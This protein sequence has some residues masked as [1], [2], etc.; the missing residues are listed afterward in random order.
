MLQVHNKPRSLNTS[1][2]CHLKYALCLTLQLLPQYSWNIHAGYMQYVPHGWMWH[3]AATI[4][5]AWA[6]GGQSRSRTWAVM[7]F[8]FTFAQGR[9]WARKEV[10]KDSLP[11]TCVCTQ[12]HTN[13]GAQR[14]S[15][16]VNS[17]KSSVPSKIFFIFFPLTKREMWLSNH[18]AILVINGEFRFLSSWSNWM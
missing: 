14:G 6:E 17:V 18:G 13:T 4:I 1:V 10:W 7:S 8:H 15:L 3:E 12:E 9:K 2:M 5:Q 16:S 11:Y